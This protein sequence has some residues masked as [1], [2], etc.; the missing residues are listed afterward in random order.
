V[1]KMIRMKK[2]NKSAREIRGSEGSEIEGLQSSE[3]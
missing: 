2:V 1:M 3:V